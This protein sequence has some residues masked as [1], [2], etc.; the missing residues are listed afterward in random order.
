MKSGSGRGGREA[1][2]GVGEVKVNEFEEGGE[3]GFLQEETRKLSLQ[4][5][6]A[7]APRVL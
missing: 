5:L 1:E 7:T 2:A 4:R 6:R 3:R